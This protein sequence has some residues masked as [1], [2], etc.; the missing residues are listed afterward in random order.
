MIDTHCHILWGVD[1]AST[2]D[3]ESMDMLK[4]AAADGIKTIVATSH[5]KMPIYPNDIHILSA[6]FYALQKELIKEQMDIEIILGGE[7]FISHHTIALLEENKFVPY[8][9]GK[10]MLVEFAW[11][12]NMFDHPTTYLQ[13]IIN[14]GYIPVIAHPERYEW[15]HEDYSLLK[16]WRDMGCLL[17]INRTSIFQLDKIAA[18]NA[19]ALRMLKDDLVDIIASDAHRC[20]APR[21]PKLSDVYRYI[22]KNYGSEKAKRYLYDNPKKIIMK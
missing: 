21:L 11:T 9:N 8:N 6:A 5:I 20:Y 1:D 13:R 15:V 4:V 18:A 16:R 7:N 10:Y 2:N 3:R 22:E 14:Y 19:T 12:K 17:Q